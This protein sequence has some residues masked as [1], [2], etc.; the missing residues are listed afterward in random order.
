V[1]GPHLLEEAKWAVDLWKRMKSETFE[2]PKAE[3]KFV[4]AAHQE[5]LDAVRAKRGMYQA[6][7][8]P[9]KFA[10]HKAVT[11][12]RKDVGDKAFTENAPRNRSPNFAHNLF[13][14]SPLESVHEIGPQIF[15]RLTGQKF[16]KKSD[17]VE[18][19]AKGIK[20]AR[21]EHRPMVLVFFRQRVRAG[22]KLTDP[23]RHTH[24]FMNWLEG[25]RSRHR[26]LHEAV[27]VLVPS[28][29]LPALSGLVDLPVYDFGRINSDTTAVIA[30]FDGSQV[31]ALGIDRDQF[32]GDW[33]NPNNPLADALFQAS[34]T[35]ELERSRLARSDRKQ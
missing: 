32:G 31:T 4:Q 3:A 6:F 29:E 20:M 17:R 33:D 23:G 14:K 7:L 11:Q 35:A 18:L 5:V 34:R 19:A 24:A 2:S 25:E 16:V 9:L 21:Q 28:S 13:A 30:N 1:N 10:S 12:K 27:V 22:E 15:T 26:D 8:K